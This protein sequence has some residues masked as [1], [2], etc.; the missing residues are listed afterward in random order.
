MQWR[1]KL[2]IIIYGISILIYVVVLLEG[3]AVVGERDAFGFAFLAWYI[4]L[5]LTSFV[6]AFLLQFND[7]YF[8]WLYPVIF[9][10]FG[11]V[12]PMIVFQTTTP[13]DGTLIPA[14]APTLIGAGVGFVMRKWN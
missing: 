2:S 11:F 7:A 9:G 14:F 6:G 5:P 1:K 8:Q 12:S 4:I 3:V 13:V 10:I